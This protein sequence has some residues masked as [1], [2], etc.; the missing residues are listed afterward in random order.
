MTWRRALV[1]V[2][3]A[4]A[5]VLSFDALRA[6]ALGAP[7]LA[8]GVIPTRTIVARE[9]LAALWAVEI[10]LAAAVGI[11]GIRDSR[12][13][14]LAWLTFVAAVASVGF[15]VF[16][17]PAIWARLVPPGALFLAIVVLELPRARPVWEP[18]PL[19][20]PVPDQPAEDEP[21]PEVEPDQP[22]PESRPRVAQGGPRRERPATLGRPVA[23]VA[24]RAAQG[25]SAAR[26]VR[27]LGL[28][29]RARTGWVADLVREHR[30]TPAQVGHRNGQGGGS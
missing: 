22:G 28:S 8:G 17:L 24:Q 4:G 27:E 23:E 3:A 13:D 30:P 7:P 21:E 1:G 10:D 14:P 15:Q 9:W 5:A 18:T 19:G 29:D 6:Y 16:A 20:H 25:H 2:L 26:I 12:K 11:L